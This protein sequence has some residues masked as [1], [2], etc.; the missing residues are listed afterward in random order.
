MRPVA[1]VAALLLA[2]PGGLSAQG[3][4]RKEAARQDSAPA[5]IG[6]GLAGRTTCGDGHGG[7]SRTAS[8][9]RTSFIAETVVLGGPADSAGIEPGD[10]L[11]AIAGQTLGTAAGDRA[12]S[13]LRVG[14]PVDVRIGR[15]GG[16]T[17]LRVVPRV[18]PSGA[19]VVRVRVASVDAEG[20][21]VVPV[22][23]APVA[24]PPVAPGSV[25]GAPDTGVPGAPASSSYILTMPARRAP[26]GSETLFR[27]DMNGRPML[28]RRMG[29]ASPDSMS[30][31]LRAL[32]DSV[33]AEARAR[34]D[35]LR[36]V[37]RS[38][39]WVALQN[40]D[41]FGAQGGT[42]R[43]A[44]AEFRPLSPELAEYFRGAS[45]GL[46]VLR[47]LPG[48]PAASLGLRPGDVVVRAA[49]EPVRDALDLRSA[50]VKVAPAD[51]VGVV[52]VR[53]GRTMTG[54]LKGR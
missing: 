17:T 1:L 51:S 14:Q 26:D 13:H 53:K 30:P 4:A 48:T 15:E 44:G 45:R 33:L 16:D 31:D 29:A 46:L 2:L 6:V 49:G 23:L 34:L 5:W 32:R 21:D 28:W 43:L 37:F 27:I 40:S 10:T 7:P 39:V 47:V 52:W 12:L 20:P 3:T 24:L 38:H 42:A 18:R 41:A 8:D 50:L 9:C 22:R 25:P 19:P 35:S 54:V 11:L 36:E